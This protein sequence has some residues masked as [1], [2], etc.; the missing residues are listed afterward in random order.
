MTT[1]EQLQSKTIILR[2]VFGKVGQKYYINPCKDPKTNRFPE[3][4]KRV[5]SQGD[6]I[7]TDAERNSGKYFVKESETFIVTDGTTYDLSNEVDRAQW[8]AIRFCP[9]IAMSRDERDS[10][11]NLKID[12]NAKRYGVAELYVEIPGEESNKRVSKR[13]MVHRAESYIF[14]DPKGA[15][16]RRIAA[17]LLGRIMNNAPDADV[18]EWLLNIASKEPQKIIEVYTGSD[19]A[20]RILFI[21]ARQKNVIY[22]KNKLFLYADNIVLGATDDAVITWMK[23]SKN[24]KVLELIKK[25]T[26]PELFGIKDE[27]KE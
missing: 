12:G 4:V 1:E 23:T 2:S 14:D 13:E 7:L 6:M 15:D 20:L 5:N 19:T 10:S 9:F 25:D 22:Q 8:E 17:K 24:S 3:C 11:G 18:K 27:D 16:G 21:D 26:Y